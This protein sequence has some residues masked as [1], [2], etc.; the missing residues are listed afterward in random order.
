MQVVEASLADLNDR[1]IARREEPLPMDRFRPNLV[2][3]GCPAFAEDT[4]PH[5]RIGA[6]SFR[7]GGPCARCIMTNA[8]RSDQAAQPDQSCA[9]HCCLSVKI[10]GAIKI[11]HVILEGSQDQPGRTA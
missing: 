8:A 4:W 7:A 11:S 6:I 1:L 9:H 2:I 3:S 10:T 5:L